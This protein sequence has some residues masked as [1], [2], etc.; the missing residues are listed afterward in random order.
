MADMALFGVEQANNGGQVILHPMV[1]LLQQNRAGFGV[2][3]GLVVQ[4]GVVDGN[5]G[6]GG[7]GL[8]HVQ[9]GLVKTIGG[10]I[11]H[12]QYPNYSV[13]NLK[14]HGQNRLNLN[15]QQLVYPAKMGIIL[16]NM[17]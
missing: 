7:Q 9:I 2:A 6:G 16:L 11:H 13:V 1:D 17:G 4:A 5:G 3:L 14:R 10:N 12:L 15:P 8:Q